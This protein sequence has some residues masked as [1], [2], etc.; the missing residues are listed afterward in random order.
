VAWACH[1]QEVNKNSKAK[2]QNGTT[3]DGT[4]TQKS[5][6]KA[7]KYV[8][9]STEH[10]QYSTENQSDK[11]TEYAERRGIE[12]IRTYADEGKSGLRIEGR[13]GLQQLIKV[14]ESGE[15][16]FQIILVYDIS[17]WGRFQDADESAYYEYICRRAG[18]QVA[19]CAEQFEN[20]GSPVSTIVKGVKRAMAGEYSR[21]LS[22][23]VF[24]GQ[25]RLIE[26]GY[27]QGGPAGY[28]LRRVLIDQTGSMKGELTRGEHKSLQTDRVILMPGPDEEV[29]VVNQIYEWFINDGLIEAEI[30]SRLNGMGVTTDLDRAWTRATVHQVLTNEKYI[31]NNVYNR[32]SFKLKKLRVVNDH[33][34]WIKKESAFE[35]IVPSEAFYTVQGMIRARNHRFT[36]EELIEKLRSLYQ[37]R[38]LLSGL[39]INETEGMPSTSA[40]IHRFGSLIRAYQAV[41]FNP[42]RDYRYLEVN[43][44]LRQ[45]HPQVIRD[46]EQK[47]RDIGGLTE[48]DNSTDLLNINREF[49]VSIV[50]S[51]CQTYETGTRR[52]KVRFDSSLQP[53]IT[54]A[55]RLNESN[56]SALDYYLLPS[57][58]FGNKGFNLA[59][60]NGIEFETYRFETLEYLYGMAERT[61][62]RRAA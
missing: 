55:V 3:L 34:M 30:A 9:M 42:D 16:D 26:M 21:E 5:I 49:T 43:R 38:G 17:R 12:I 23:K 36:N 45:M 33:Q 59:E 50:L 11:I 27:R 41:G 8:R 61:R 2:M 20:D 48:R 25:C 60:R 4:P 39:I 14:V 44:L 10:Q 19:Y 54:V 51:R 29:H 46:T 52:W 53:D 40:Y 37:S 58:D 22:T 35:A 62:V 32:I 18:I 1:K 15:A 57:L 31:G 47:I 6:F 28:G 56:Q 13:V 7:V 24:A